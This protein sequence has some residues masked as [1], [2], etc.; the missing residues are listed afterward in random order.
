MT[1][2]DT[3]LLTGCFDVPGGCHS[4]IIWYDKDLQFLKHPLHVY[5][6]S[7][8]YEGRYNPNRAMIRL[9]QSVDILLRRPWYG[10]VIVAKFGS[11][12]CTGYIDLTHDDIVHIRDYFA[13][14]A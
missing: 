7:Q 9:T 6:C 14:F 4:F 2:Q 5:Y 1:T 3:I 11:Y 12:A 13:Y 10:S 8:G